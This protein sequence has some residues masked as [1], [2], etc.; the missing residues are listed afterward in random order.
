MV[1]PGRYVITFAATDMNGTGLSYEWDM[2]I[3]IAPGGNPGVTATQ[4]RGAALANVQ[5]IS[6]GC[7]G[8]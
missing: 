4:T 5:D 8:G 7:W 2:P 3:S 1:P 6:G